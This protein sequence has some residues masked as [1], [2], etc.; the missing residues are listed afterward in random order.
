MNP[1]DD[2][3][4]TGER[5]IGFACIPESW[6]DDQPACEYASIRLAR[7][8]VVTLETMR[9]VRAATATHHPATLSRKK[10][11][12]EPRPPLLLDSGRKTGTSGW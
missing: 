2:H 10:A 1:T 8:K 7:P 11:A 9:M 12:A 3:N 4:S 6:L 5:N